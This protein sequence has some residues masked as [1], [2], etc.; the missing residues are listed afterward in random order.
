MLILKKTFES[1]TQSCD[2]NPGRLLHH[3]CI[4][5]SP[6]SFPLCFPSL[7]VQ[8]FHPLILLLFLSSSIPRSPALHGVCLI[9]LPVHPIERSAR[10]TLPA[11]RGDARP[12]RPALPQ[13]PAR[14]EERRGKEESAN[15]LMFSGRSN[16]QF[17]FWNKIQIFFFMLAQK[18]DISSYL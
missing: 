8:P 17:N 7:C 9:S 14:R 1:L 6:S 13:N 2:R 18:S 11:R 16:K 5:P 12:R 3:H 10:L 15:T 4:P